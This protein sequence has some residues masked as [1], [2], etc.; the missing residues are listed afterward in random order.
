MK[1]KRFV[2]SLV[3][4]LTVV[5]LGGFVGCAVTGT[6]KTCNGNGECSSCSGTG[7]KLADGSYVGGNPCISCNGTGKCIAC[8]GTGTVMFK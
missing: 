3:C 7:N 1:R 2:V 4:L 5:T 6:C 8:K